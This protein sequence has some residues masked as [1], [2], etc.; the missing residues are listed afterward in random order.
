MIFS[1][2]DFF[3][4][5]PAVVAV[6]WIIPTKFKWIWL[7]AA[8]YVFCISWDI[9][10][11]IA[12][13]LVTVISYI[14]GVLLDNF[15]Q[16]FRALFCVGVILLC[17]SPLLLFKVMGLFMREYIADNN[18]SLV[19]P[20]GFS[21]YVFQAVGYLIDVYRKKVNAEKNF[22][23]YSLFLA[24][25]PRF[26]SG[27]IERYDKFNEQISD[28]PNSSFDYN[29]TKNGLILMMWGYFQKMVVADNLTILVNQIYDEW[30]QYSGTVVAVGTVLYAI[31]LYADFAGY[32]NIAMGAARILGFSLSENFRQ[33]YMATSIKDFWRRWHISLSA[34]L[35]DYIY[36]SLGGNRKGR[37]LKYV[38]IFL[39]FVVSGLWHGTSWSFVAWG[40]IHGG[41]QI[42]GEFHQKI[43]GR[44]SKLFNIKKSHFLY[45]FG[46]RITVFL[47]VDIAWL[48]FRADGLKTAISMLRHCILDVELR[49]LINGKFFYMGL[50][51]VEVIV[52]FI[53]IMMMI[54]VDILHE[55]EFHFR[56]W[57][58][59]QK[60]FIR[61]TCYVVMF[62]VL[63]I[64]ATRQIGADASQFIYAQ[65]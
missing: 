53:A 30:N 16:K 65:F 47:L 63:V 6:Y 55:K 43:T 8:S 5:F 41:Y 17:V 38:N 64:A 3:L 46:Q 59:K 39:T 18:I 61:W 31:Q 58:I 42:A 51:Q 45:K 22:G 14:S 27:P 40:M 10:A 52:L 7:L 33:P 37:L 13:F 48:F 23:K 21:F 50:H 44:L 11:G 35:R 9:R 54:I 2:F 34:W 15:V 36:I 4:F 62:C 1:S 26:L 60:I 56:E 24:F 29:Q 19:L 28:V 20:L 49:D 57:L 12:L 32:S 25:F